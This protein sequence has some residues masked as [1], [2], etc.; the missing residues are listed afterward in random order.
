M[1]VTVDR[2]T[3]GVRIAKHEWRLTTDN[4]RPAEFIVGMVDSLEIEMPS[5]THWHVVFG[6]KDQQRSTNIYFN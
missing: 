4:D 3:K 1:D 5:P 2:C 6:E